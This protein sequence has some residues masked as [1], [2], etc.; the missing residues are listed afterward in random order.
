MSVSVLNPS[1]VSASGTVPG[2]T[3][4]P[5]Q[6]S[7]TYAVIPEMTLTVTTHG[8]NVL[9]A[10]DGSFDLQSGDDWLVS[11]FVDGA[12]NSASEREAKFFGGSLLG[13]TPAEVQ[14]VPIGCSA[15]V[16]GLAAGSHT[17]DARWRRLAGTARALSTQRQLS[18][19]E[20]L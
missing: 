18:V 2:T 10:F 17:F 20:V 5:T 19:V 7:G 6:T 16:T 9:V 12:Q 1:D 11:I 13:L 15:L 8:G 14:A 4:A 3:S